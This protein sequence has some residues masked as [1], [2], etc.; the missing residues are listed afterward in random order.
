MKFSCLFPQ[1]II[2]ENEISYKLGSIIKETFYNPL[3]ITGSKSLKESKHYEKIINS[4]IKEKID[5]I[6]YSGVSGE[7]TPQIIDEITEFAVNKNIKSVIAIGGGSVIDCGKAVSGLVVNK[8]GVENYLEGVGKGYKITQKPIP[9]AAVPTT[10]GSGAEATKNSVVASRDKKYKKSFRDDS[11][12]AKMIIADPLLTF[13]LPRKETAYGGMDAISQLIESFVSKKRNLFCMGLA[14]SFI[15]SSLTAIVKAYEDPVDIQARSVMLTS[16]I[17]SGICLANA[18]LGAVHGFASGIGGMFEIPHGLICAVLLPGICKKNSI[19]K[20]E[21]YKELAQL[22]NYD[23]SNDVN[24]FID[25]LYNINRKLSIP[26][27]FKDYSI[28]LDKA[29]EIV[30]RSQGSSM[31][32]NPVEFK[33]EEWIEFIKNYL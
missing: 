27:D 20:P 30:D 10:A 12:V 13:S 33:K 11:L 17:V 6:E 28:P 9:F 8:K 32:G 21:I 14:S 2:F 4:I 23:G 15:P 26:F 16:S 25:L 22:G 31:S 5:F 29:D 18:G 19:K 3:I 24:K 7:P 1:K